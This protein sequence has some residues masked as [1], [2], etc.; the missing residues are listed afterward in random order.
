ME[1]LERPFAGVAD[2]GQQQPAE[3]QKVLGLGTLEMPL[4]WVEHLIYLARDAY[5]TPHVL[6]SCL[7][8]DVGDSQNTQERVFFQEF[9]HLVTYQRELS[10]VTFE[11][12]V[13]AWLED[14]K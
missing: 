5:A 1:S 4:E 13:V 10:P 14:E 6:C 3:D 9:S 7:C 11:L 12:E 8:W 2:Q